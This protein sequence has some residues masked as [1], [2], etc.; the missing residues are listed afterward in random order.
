MNAAPQTDQTDAR[1]FPPSVAPRAVSPDMPL[2]D[3]T[4][5]FN[6]ELSTLD[7]HQRVLHQAL[8][9]RIPLLERVFFCA[10]TGSNLDEFFRKRVGGLKRQQAAGVS[11]LS[12]DGRTPAEQLALVRTAALR[13]YDA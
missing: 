13:L 1:T 10:I 6:R 4:L 8:D 7:F 11:S 9:E 12:P 3:P 5:F 2:D